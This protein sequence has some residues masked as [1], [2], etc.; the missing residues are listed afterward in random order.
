MNKFFIDNWKYIII[1]LGI[2]IVAALGSLF[3][4]LG[5][6][7]FSTLTKPSIFV[8]SF[9]IPIAWS[10]IYTTF[11]IVLCLW[12]KKENLKKDTIILLILN[13]ILNILWCLFF[14]TFNNT[15]LGLVAIII[16]LILAILLIINIYNTKPIYSY[17]LSIYPLWLSIATCLNL[18][19]WIL[20]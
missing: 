17:I 9:I 12:V 4:S 15:L 18:A 8:S 16:N 7:W 1:V 11:A 5:L 3:V 20:N 14:F 13:G 10:I 6:D 19:T 2:I